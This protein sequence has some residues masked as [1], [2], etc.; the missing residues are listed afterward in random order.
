M[1]KKKS[2]KLNQTVNQAIKA[3][4]KAGWDEGGSYTGTDKSNPFVT[5]TQDVDDL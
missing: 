3:Y 4:Q 5:P 2:T 1:A